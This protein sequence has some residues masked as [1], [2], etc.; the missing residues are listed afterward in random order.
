MSYRI[1]KK[2]K[3]SQFPISVSKW[4]PAK[5]QECTFS[6]VQPIVYLEPI[7]A[8]NISFHFNWFLQSLLLIYLS[9]YN[10]VTKLVFALL[11]SLLTKNAMI[12][13]P[14]SHFVIFGQ[15]RI[16]IRCVSLDTSQSEIIIFS[17]YK[18]FL[19]FS[20]DSQLR[21]NYSRVHLYLT[22]SLRM[23]DLEINER[24]LN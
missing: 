5:R 3:L 13:F 17:K 21:D 8:D 20:F 16:W 22:F 1:V 11:L 18:I 6:S 4:L 9:I 24:N 10:L 2:P 14:M 7:Y 12:S 23:R 19:R 15:G